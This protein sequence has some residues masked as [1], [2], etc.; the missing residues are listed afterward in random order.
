MQ[1]ADLLSNGDR[2][3]RASRWS[4][5]ELHVLVKRSL[6]LIVITFLLP[7]CTHQFPEQWV[8]EHCCKNLSMPTG[9][10]PA[11]RTS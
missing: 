2:A 8:L 4:L 6:L 11:G 1:P 3:S 5:F 9:L 7:R 10:S